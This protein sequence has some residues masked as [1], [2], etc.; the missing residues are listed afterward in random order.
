M[1]VD[2]GRILAATLTTSDVDDPSQVGP[3]LDR[4]T[5]LTASFTADCAYDQEGVYGDVAAQYPDATVIVP[6]RSSPLP[7]SRVE[8]DPSKR[9]W[10]LQGIS[11][12]GPM[13]SRFKRV[14]GDALRSQ[15]DRRCA[16]EVAI[17]VDALNRMLEL[18]RP[19]YVRFA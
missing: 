4:V 9:D 7:S 12:H 5:N 14:I 6:P 18:G 8:M 16:T 13:M 1:D 3:L 15:T 17:A 11:E 19:S 10:Y 2:T